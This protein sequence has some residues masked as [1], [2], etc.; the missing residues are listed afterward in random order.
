MYPVQVVPNQP[1]RLPESGF[2]GPTGTALGCWIVDGEAKLPGDTIVVTDDVTITAEWRM[3]SDGIGERLAG[4][5]LSLDGD[6]AVKFYMELADEVAGSDDAY[7][8]FI[9]PNGTKTI[10][11]KIPVW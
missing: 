5:S 3:F 7:M 8:Q 9:I 4:Y 10:T 6:I 2:T 1:Y 11:E